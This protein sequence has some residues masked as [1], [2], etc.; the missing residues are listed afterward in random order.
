MILH[1]YWSFLS[2]IM[3][4]KAARGQAPSVAFIPGWLY[5]NLTNVQGCYTTGPSHIQSIGSRQW[6][7]LNLTN[8]RSI[9]VYFE[10]VLML[11]ILML[12]ILMLIM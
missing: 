3:A 5:L 10:I 2:D 7:Y 8:V 12:I 11:I 9:V 4:V 6:L 1:F